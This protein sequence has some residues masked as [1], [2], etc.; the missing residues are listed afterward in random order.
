MGLGLLGPVPRL[1]QPNGRYWVYSRL[2][3]ST[4]EEEYISGLSNQENVSE[5]LQSIDVQ[6]SNKQKFLSWDRIF[7]GRIG[8]SLA[9]Y[10][11]PLRSSG[12]G[13]PPSPLT[14]RPW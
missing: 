4:V 12:N 8:R 5:F 10:P 3:G 11:K 1:I 9:C 7:A 2:C 14:A 13:L 6:Q